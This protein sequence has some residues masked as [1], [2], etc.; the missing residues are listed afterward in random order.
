[1]EHVSTCTSADAAI[2]HAQTAPEPSTDPVGILES[3]TRINDT[4][5][6]RA[7]LRTAN[8]AATKRQISAS[9]TSDAHL[10]H[11]ITAIEELDKLINTAAKRVRVWCA[12]YDPELEHS[13]SDHAAF[14]A[15]LLERHTRAPDTMGGDTDQRDLDLLLAHTA[16]VHG[17]IAHRATLAI[18]VDTAMERIA[19]NLRAVAGSMIGAK[20]LA[21]AGSLDR[22]AILPAGTIQLLGAETALFRHL[23]N[24]AARPPKHGV[25]FNHQLIQ[26]A[27]QDDRG[28]VARSLA[29]EIA[30]AARVD[31]FKGAFVG[32]ELARK[33][34]ARAD[35]VRAAHRPRRQPAQIYDDRAPARSHGANRGGQRGN[36]RGGRR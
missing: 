24:R 32:D 28:R 2:A 12:L 20:L 8:I 18:G 15:A 33:A 29:S 13:I 35:A 11:A 30:I 1:M 14:I 5:H 9:V 17:L 7:L 26:Q 34:Q 10:T 25:I 36:Q 22:L 21:M 4:P 3:L 16:A 6:A 23:R 31:R 27:R 19:P